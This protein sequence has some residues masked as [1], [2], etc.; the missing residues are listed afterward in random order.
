MS[1]ARTYTS[2]EVGR[3]LKNSEGTGLTRERGA[4]HA[5]GLH[6]IGAAGR[7]RDSTT[8]VGLEERLIDE[9]KAKVGAFDN[10]QVDAITAALNTQA[11]QN[12][13]RH[14][15][16]STVWYVFVK[17]SIQHGNFQMA[18]SESDLPANRASGPMTK[19]QTR[20][21]QALFVAMKLMKDDKGELHIRTAFPL[22]AAPANG[23]SCSVTY[24]GAGQPQS[25]AI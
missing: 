8:T 21:C 19:P 23:A 24:R 13:L 16:V 14:L 3:L 1:I 12:S 25:L 5:E 20:S 2:A 11:G 4:G 6:A 10:C 18:M 17:I 22:D 7:G 15:A 9:R